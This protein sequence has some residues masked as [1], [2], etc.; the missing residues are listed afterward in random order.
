M[1]NKT[2]LKVQNLSNTLPP[3]DFNFRADDFCLNNLVSPSPVFAPDGL[4][5]SADGVLSGKTGLVLVL[6]TGLSSSKRLDVKDP[7]ELDMGAAFTKATFP[8]KC[9]NGTT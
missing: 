5:A 1:R 4:E 9:V 7:S 2:L 3:K 6:F 8:A